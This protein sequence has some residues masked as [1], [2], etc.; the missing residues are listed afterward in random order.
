VLRDD[1]VAK[2]QI[3]AVAQP[4]LLDEP[5]AELLARPAGLELG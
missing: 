4:G 1:Q 5:G 3:D 2:V